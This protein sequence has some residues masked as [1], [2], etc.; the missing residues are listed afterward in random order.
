MPGSHYGSV[1]VIA[2]PAAAGGRDQSARLEQV[3]SRLRSAGRQVVIVPTNGP[4]DGRIQAARVAASHETLLAAGGDGTFREL[5]D[6]VLSN[7]DAHP[8]V[9]ALAFGTGND[10]AQLLHQGRDEA[11]VSAVLEGGSRPMD[12][13]E[14]RL[15]L[16][17]VEAVH[18]AL[19]FAAVGFSGNLLQATT[20][21]AKRWFGSHLSYPVG[22]FRALLRYRPVR[23]RVTTE[24]HGMPIEE[25]LV[26]A[27]LANAPHAGG[28]TMRIAPGARLDD[29]RGEVSLV[30]AVGRWE[31]ARQFV[32][33][34]QGTHIRHPRV[35]YGPGNR[36]SVEADPPQGV[37]LDGDLLGQTPVTCRILPGALRVVG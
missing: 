7:P 15:H 8:R 36:L 32:R 33:L 26:L 27:M 34:V 29:G 16:A 20:P 19:L 14:A 1:A 24:S 4:G 10:C 31:L 22:F 6:G 17:G 23:L 3:V 12:V 35:V 21:R 30:R 9:G 28:R 37:A 5:V 11:V 18:H 2:N 13:I 25:S